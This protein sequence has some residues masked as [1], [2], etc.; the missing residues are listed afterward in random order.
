MLNVIV[1][2]VSVLIVGLVV[3]LGAIVVGGF[4]SKQ[5]EIKHDK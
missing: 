1:M 4:S 2:V 3:G 5:E